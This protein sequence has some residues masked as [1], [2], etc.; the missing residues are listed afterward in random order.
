[1]KPKQT[2]HLEKETKMAK[3]KKSQE[4][5]LVKKISTATVYGKITNEDKV[6]PK[7]L[8]R[9]FGL[10]AGTKTGSTQFGDWSCFVGEFQAVNLETGEIF[11]SG[12][13]FLP[14]IVESGILAQ[15][16]QAE[17]VKFAF[18]IGIKPN[19][20]L[21]IGYEYTA[22]SLLQPQANNFLEQMAQEVLAL[23]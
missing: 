20:D 22:K 15:L 13:C 10:A 8:Y 4:A 17:G 12:K 6:K 11:N 14:E 18:E 19:E 23:N 7:A 2:N 3:S 21:G 16:S 1:M 5:S 9:V